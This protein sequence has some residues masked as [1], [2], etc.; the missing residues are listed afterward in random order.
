MI[1]F[2]DDRLYAKGTC[3]V[4]CSD[5]N[6]GDVLYQS[7]KVTTGSITPSVNLNEIRAGLTNPIATMI[8]SDS[9]LQVDFEAADFQIWAKAAQM[10][11]ALSYG[12]P[13]QTC[14]VLT[15]DSTSLAID[16]TD[17]VPAAPFGYASPFCFVQ[18]VGAESKL[19][20]DGV[21]YPISA[22][23]TISNFVATAGTQYKVT[24]YVQKVG[25]RKAVISSFIDPKVVRFEAQIAV[26][27]NRGGTSEGT[28][29]G[30][31]YYTIPYL[32]LQADATITGDQSTNDTTKISGQAL[33]YDASVVSAQCSDCDAST[34]AYL[35]YVPDDASE[36]ILGIAVIGGAIEVVTN[37]TA[38]LKPYIVMADK[39]IVVPT[40]YADGF[41]YAMTT[42]ISGT[43]VSDSGLITAGSTAGNGEATITYT[44]GSKEYTCPVNVTVVQ[45][46]N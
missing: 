2:T 36:E 9:S 13:V 17:G 39:S 27:S 23:G 46:S 22:E 3:N 35:V 14:Q 8:P 34:L 43:T 6:T 10:G 42:A 29:V 15:A 7:N 26:Y 5:V 33:A 4:I 25:A 37:Q 11:A 20:N 38:Q 1:S 31:I 30:W 45:S 32:K 41:A 28:R 12:A 19:L 40:D 16:I 18:T 21:A 44:V 24:Y